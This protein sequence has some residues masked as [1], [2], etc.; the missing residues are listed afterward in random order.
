MLTQ[1]RSMHVII[2]SCYCDYVCVLQV[3][4]PTFYSVDAYSYSHAP[5]LK[6]LSLLLRIFQGANFY[7]YNNLTMHNDVLVL[8][9]AAGLRGGW[10]GDNEALYT[11]GS[12]LIS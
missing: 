12:N 3:I 4:I 11:W 7:P 6:C 2:Y 1:C 5:A 9:V 8:Q 10:H